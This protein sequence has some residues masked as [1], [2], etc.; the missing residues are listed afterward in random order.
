MHLKYIIMVNVSEADMLLF[1]QKTALGKIYE[2]G[3]QV[4]RIETFLSVQNIY[5]CER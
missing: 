2:G 4:K 3:F 1:S 5:I